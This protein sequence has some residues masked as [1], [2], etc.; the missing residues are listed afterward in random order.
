MFSCDNQSTIS[1]SID[2]PA[3]ETLYWVSFKV[4][5]RS[6]DNP[7]ICNVEVFKNGISHLNGSTTPDG[8]FFDP[9]TSFKN[10]DICQVKITHVT[11]GYVLYQSIPWKPPEQT[12]VFVDSKSKAR[13]NDA[14]IYVDVCN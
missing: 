11:D 2:Q 8:W 13:T 4:L 5:C 10:D 7:V 12:I 14:V 1:E 3:G 6:N 9:Y